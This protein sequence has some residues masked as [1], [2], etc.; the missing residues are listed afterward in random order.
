MY[1]EFRE[2]FDSFPPKL[3]HN[4]ESGANMKELQEDIEILSKW[5]RDWLLGFTRKK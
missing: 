4:I 3:Y 5:S 2:A 1:L